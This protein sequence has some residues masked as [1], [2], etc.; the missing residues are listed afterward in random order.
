MRRIYKIAILV[1]VCVVLFAG[2]VVIQ[3]ELYKAE[4]F[5]NLPKVA[6]KQVSYDVSNQTKTTIELQA[7][8]YYRGRFNTTLVLTRA[9]VFK[10]F[11][12]RWTQVEKVTLDPKVEMP[13]DQLMNITFSFY[14]N[15]LPGN[16]TVSLLTAEGYAF[17]SPNFEIKG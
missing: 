3:R 16:Y 14:G 2:V 7:Q 6:I 4:F 15:L 8:W 10:A 5:R 1:T 11:G 17:N 13:F 9:L 12:P